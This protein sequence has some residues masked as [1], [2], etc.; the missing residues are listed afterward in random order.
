MED[1]EEKVEEV[2]EKVAESESFA[3]AQEE[4]HHAIEA[5]KYILSNHCEENIPPKRT[6]LVRITSNFDGCTSWILNTPEVI[7]KFHREGKAC[8]SVSC[9]HAST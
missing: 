7:E 3:S 5:V 1:L 2:A 6:G 9:N 8:L 4:M